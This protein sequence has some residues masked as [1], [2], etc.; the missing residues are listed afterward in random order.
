MNEIYCFPSP[1][2]RRTRC[3]WRGVRAAKRIKSRCQFATTRTVR[4]K[5][6]A[7]KSHG[8]ADTAQPHLG[9]QLQDWEK[10]QRKGNRELP[11]RY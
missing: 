6:E 9:Q 10:I 8:E 7:V 4:L 11:L 3:D 5:V 1:R 2:K